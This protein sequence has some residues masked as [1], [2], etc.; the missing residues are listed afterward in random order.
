[1]AFL[2]HLN[3]LLIGVDPGLQFTLIEP[4]GDARRPCCKLISQ[5]ERDI[6]AVSTGITHEIERLCHW[7]CTFPWSP[8][9]AWLLV[10]WPADAALLLVNLRS[11]ERRV[12]KEC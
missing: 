6:P 2:E 7:S 8:T 10:S 12:G 5:F 11:E 4:N 9:A 1:M 3:D